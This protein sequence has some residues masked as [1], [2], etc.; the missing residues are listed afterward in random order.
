M[1]ALLIGLIA[2]V[3]PG[4]AHGLISQRRAMWTIIA[5]FVVSVALVNFT[6]WA[7]VAPPLVLAGS[8]IDA[9]RRYHRLR[10]A[11]RW[12]WLDPVI[13]LVILIPICLGLRALVV[14]A[15]R[16]PSS[17]QYPTLHIGDHIFIGKLVS[18]W[19]APKR[20]ELIVFR[21]PCAPRVDYI[22]RVI[23]IG[24]DTIEVRCSTVYLNGAAVARTL[25]DANASYADRD[26]TNDAWHDREVSRYRETL[27]GITHDVFHER[28]LPQRDDHRRTSMLDEDRSDFP[29]DTLPTCGDFPTSSP[30]GTVQSRPGRLVSTGEH[31]TPCAPFRHYVVP[32]DHVFVLGDNRSNSNDSRYWGSVPIGNVKGRVVGIWYP[33]SRFGSVH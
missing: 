3:A 23:A 21:Q 27:D 5:A 4:F 22:S 1:D 26:E 28:E 12:S 17:S 13:S 2:L 24:G 19:R 29:R 33:L 7:L 18:Q 30:D 14:E 15:F 10:G 11:V 9:G 20:G 31:A 16:L 25:V 32:E 6:I 8:M